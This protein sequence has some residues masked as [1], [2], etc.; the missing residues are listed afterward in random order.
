MFRSGIHQLAGGKIGGAAVLVGRAV[1]IHRAADGNGAAGAVVII[2]V[3][4]A[5][6]VGGRI[7]AATFGGR[8]SGHAASDG[9]GAAV[10]VA[11]SVVTN[12]RSGSYT[13]TSIIRYI[14]P[15]VLFQNIIGTIS[16]I[17]TSG[18]YLSASDADIAALVMIMIIIYYDETASYAGSSKTA[19]GCNSSAVDGDATT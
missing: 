10:T 6:A 13:R 15:R 14:C 3:V 17:A 18:C 1:P 19:S 5:N 12:S 4:F 11:C 7:S 2:A 9:D 8:D 16:A